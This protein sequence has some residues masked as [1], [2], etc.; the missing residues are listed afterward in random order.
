VAEEGN[1]DKLVGIGLQ[2]TRASLTEFIRLSDVGCD[3]LRQTVILAPK[4]W[5][6]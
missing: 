1:L 6:R 3:G 5:P 2:L 4:A